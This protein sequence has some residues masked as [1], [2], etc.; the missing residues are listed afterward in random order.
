MLKQAHGQLNTHTRAVA[1]G[2]GHMSVPWSRPGHVSVDH[3]QSF[4]DCQ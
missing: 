3:L 4:I 2:P 1:D